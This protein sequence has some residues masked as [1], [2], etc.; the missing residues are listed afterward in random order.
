VG[1]KHQ[2]ITMTKQ[3]NCFLFICFILSAFACDS[4]FFKQKITLENKVWNS[5]DTIAFKFEITDTS[6]RY[7]ISLNIDHGTNYNYQNLYLKIDVQ[8]PSKRLAPQV[9]P[10]DLST[11]KGKWLGDCS[12]KS[13]TG[14]I[15]FLPNT[16]FDEIGAYTIHLVQHSRETNL[17]AVEAIGLKIKEI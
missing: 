2:K 3:A 12:D 1:L 5:S 17:D 15:P 13:C 8:T 4:Y 14:S 7:N 10:V 11:K 6:K 9:V 16:K